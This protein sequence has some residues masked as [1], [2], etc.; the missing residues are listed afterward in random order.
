MYCDPHNPTKSIKDHLLDNHRLSVMVLVLFFGSELL[1]D[2]DTL[3]SDQILHAVTLDIGSGDDSSLVLA[4]VLRVHVLRL[5][6]LVLASL[7]GA[8][9]G[10]GGC[11]PLEADEQRL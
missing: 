5:A 9:V 11:H 6:V 2:G 4:L 7:L 3:F 1:T 10:R 8:A